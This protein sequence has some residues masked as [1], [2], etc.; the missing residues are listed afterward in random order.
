MSRRALLLLTVVGLTVAALPAA[1]AVRPWWRV[2]AIRS[3]PERPDVLLITM[4]TTRADKLG[5]YGGDPGV[6]PAL[7]ALARN[8]VLFRRAYS[9]VPVTL[10]S[11]SS[12]LTGLSPARH[13][14]HDNGTFVLDAAP[15]TLAEAFTKAGYRTAAFVSSVILDRKFGLARGFERYE[16]SLETDESEDILVQVPAEVTVGRA[17]AWVRETDPRPVFAWVHL[18]DPHTPYDPPELFAARFPGKPYDGE[19]A[20]MDSQIGAL[21]AG[22]AERKRPTLVAAIADHGESLGEH[23]EP[24]HAFFVYGATQHV[25]LIVSY[26][27]VLAA[28]SE[29]APLVR[30]VDLAPTLLEIAHLPVPEGL[31][32]RSLVP[33]ATGASDRETGPA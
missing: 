9:H 13:G 28:G 32:G 27:G 4:D 21:L 26:P 15:P 18:Y 14:V 10:P 11:H 25:P 22:L 6:S 29:V 7:D 8:G 2:R 12:I 1:R 3:A 23:Q 24:T 20:Y 33:L 19:I 31:D 17:L 30:S 16:D 5:C